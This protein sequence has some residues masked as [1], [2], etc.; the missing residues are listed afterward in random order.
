VQNISRVDSRNIVSSFAVSARWNRRNFR[1]AAINETNH[2]LVNS[3][4]ILTISVMFIARAMAGEQM[5]MSEHQHHHHMVADD[6][7]I[8][9]SEVEYTIPA[10]TLIRSDGTSASF[11]K[12]IDD[13]RPVIVNFIYTSCTA[14]CPLTSQV[15]SQVQ[16]KLAASHEKVRL[17]SISID[18]EYD[19][20]ERLNRYAKTYQASQDWVFYTGTTAASLAIQKAFNAYRGDKMS[21]VPVT[22]LRAAPNKTWVR[23]D[24]FAN[25][26][27]VI[28]ELH[29]LTAR[30]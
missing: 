15:F 16:K 12:E 1:I 17:I 10:L 22:F 3:L 18:P 30:E 7:G 4:L 19:T 20:P 11:P 6:T 23:L 8:K 26:D 21:H 5:D 24:G 27:E 13:G 9:R 14:I 25:P 2:F 29:K 28:Q